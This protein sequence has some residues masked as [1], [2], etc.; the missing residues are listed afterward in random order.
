MKLSRT[1]VLAPCHDI[2]RL[3]CACCHW[4]CPLWQRLGEWWEEMIGEDGVGHPKS[5]IDWHSRLRSVT[6]RRGVFTANWVTWSNPNH[7]F[8]FTIR[9]SPSLLAPSDLK[10]QQTGRTAPWVVPSHRHPNS[11]GLVQQENLPDRP[12][13]TQHHPKPSAGVAAVD[14]RP[15]T[16]GFTLWYTLTAPWLQMCC[17]IQDILADSSQL[18]TQL[19][20]RVVGQHLNL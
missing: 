4:A 3:M 17:L 6:A 8:R 9:I 13:G 20:P 1:F 5:I 16:P 11:R 7:R 2:L 19:F 10:L 15:K 14:S 18:T 12:A